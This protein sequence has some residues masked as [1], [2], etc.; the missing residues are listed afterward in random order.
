MYLLRSEE[1]VQEIPKV[2]M[3]Q[4]VPVMPVIDLSLLKIKPDIKKLNTSKSPVPYGLHPR[5][6]KEEGDQ[7][8]EPFKILFNNSLNNGHLQMD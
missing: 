4:V 6:I 7:L 2:P 8:A 1:S 3:K 5:I